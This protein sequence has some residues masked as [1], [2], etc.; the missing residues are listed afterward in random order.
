MATLYFNAA[1]DSDWNTLGNWW[2]DDTFTTPATS[3]PTS[4]D[5][6]VIKANVSSNSGSDPT[7]ANL[8]MQSETFIALGGMTLTVTGFCTFNGWLYY[9]GTIYGDCTCTFDNGARNYG[10]ITGDCTFDTGTQNNGSIYGDCT[11]NDDSTNELPGIITGTCTF[12]DNS[13]NYGTIYG[14]SYNKNYYGGG[15]GGSVIGNCTFNDGSV[16]DDNA[17][18]FG[19]CVFNDSSRNRGNVTGS[20]TF[21]GS[22]YNKR[23]IYGDVILAYEKGI[24]GSSILGIVSSSS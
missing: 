21:R 5:D 13:P 22:S 4:V 23:G 17:Y 10:T 24:N 11:F 12:T 6:V 20:A 1:V 18:V 19:D 15:Q 14:N 8:L 3:L 16:N 2:L 7:V 9:Y